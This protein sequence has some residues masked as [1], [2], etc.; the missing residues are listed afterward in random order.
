[1][2]DPA[3]LDQLVNRVARLMPSGLTDAS[4]DLKKNLSAVL[5]A[6]FER[7]DLVTREEFDIQTQV[8]RKTREKVTELSDKIAELEENR[9]GGS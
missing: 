1:M 4:D 6:W 3:N 8:L 9:T 2:I 7:L 5:N